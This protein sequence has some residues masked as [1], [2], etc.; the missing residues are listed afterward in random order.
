MAILMNRLERALRYEPLVPPINKPICTFTED[1][2]KCFLT[3]ICR[4]SQIELSI[5]HS[6]AGCLHILTANLTNGKQNIC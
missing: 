6:N 4:I 5:L 2:T 1:E 3:G